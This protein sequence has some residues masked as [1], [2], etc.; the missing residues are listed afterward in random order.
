ML[1]PGT[2]AG[3]EGLR[4][5]RAAPGR[6]VVALD[7]D[8]TLAPVVARPQDAVPAPGA[9]EAL[10]RLA[11]R[12]GT[13]ALVTGRPA[14]AVVALA[15]LAE[16]PGLV[17]L[18]QYGAQRW[19]GALHSAAPAPGLREVR[20]ALPALLGDARLEDKGLSLVVHV[21]GLPDPL[22]EL[23]RLG[24]PV[25]RLAAEH[26]LQVHPGRGVLEVRPPGHDKR[27]ALLSLCAHHP[28]AV[29]FAGDDVGDL[30][31]FD[32]VDE[33]R[34]QG[35]PGLLVCSASE[36]GPAALRSRAYVVADGPAGVVALLEELLQQLVR[37][38]AP[39]GVVARLEEPP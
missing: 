24:P 14:E 36:E 35:V 31:A 37:T 20:R 16:V 18:G 32:A 39:A 5:L 4:A 29:L 13:L 12:V 34:A 2:D 3:R 6:A 7:Y 25:R 23:E 11:G 1:R 17:V 26:G 9:L 28:S 8:G 38:D 21:R 10:T 30:P 22:A 33:L 15:G 27:A 19:D